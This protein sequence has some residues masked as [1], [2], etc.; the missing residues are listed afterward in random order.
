VVKLGVEKV[1]RLII[2]GWIEYFFFLNEATFLLKTTIK[3]EVT[4][5]AK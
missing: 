5:E 4:E 3:I 2:L 1:K